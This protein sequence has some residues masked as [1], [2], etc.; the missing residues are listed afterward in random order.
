MD[1]PSQKNNKTHLRVGESSNRKA[2]YIYKCRQAHNPTKM[3]S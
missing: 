1:N 3:T 2:F